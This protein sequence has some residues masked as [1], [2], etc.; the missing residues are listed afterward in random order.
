M[1][2]GY[3]DSHMIWTVSN[4]KGEKGLNLT[5]ALKLS[6]GLINLVLLG[7]FYFRALILLIICKPTFIQP[8]RRFLIINDNR[9]DNDYLRMLC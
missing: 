1:K 7:Y 5:W 4:D 3:T 6:V 8:I 2:I 9:L